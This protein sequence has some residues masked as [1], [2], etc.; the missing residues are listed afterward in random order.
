LKRTAASAS[1][2]LAYMLVPD[3]DNR[4]GM[5]I[6]ANCVGAHNV[7]EAARV[8]KDRRMVWASTQAVYGLAESYLNNEPLG[9]CESHS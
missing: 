2:S 9:Y 7:L 5:A 8:S 6:Q 4:S 1:S 3:I